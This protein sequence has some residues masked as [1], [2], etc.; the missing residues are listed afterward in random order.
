MVN[1][2]I[3]RLWIGASLISLLAG[4]GVS[5]TE[6]EDELKSATVLSFVRHSE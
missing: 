6:P 2:H 1:L 4:F 5:A 3:T